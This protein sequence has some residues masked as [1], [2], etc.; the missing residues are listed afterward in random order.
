MAMTI[1]RPSRVSSPRSIIAVVEL[2]RSSSLPMIS[3]WLLQPIQVVPAVLHDPSSPGKLNQPIRT[4]QV[5]GEWGYRPH[6]GHRQEGGV[7]SQSTSS[8][9]PGVPLGSMA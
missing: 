6:P 2:R 7:A 1:Q 9:A 5:A 4:F 3:L 8:T